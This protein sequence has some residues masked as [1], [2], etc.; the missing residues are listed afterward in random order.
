METAEQEFADQLNHRRLTK[1][2]LRLAEE[3]KKIKESPASYAIRG[4]PEQPK[5][6]PRKP[7][8]EQPTEQLRLFYS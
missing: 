5:R 3:A 4:E 2:Y 8:N 7:K 6:K 1:A